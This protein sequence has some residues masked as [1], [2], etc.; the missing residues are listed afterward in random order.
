METKKRKDAYKANALEMP[1]KQLLWLTFNGFFL[2]YNAA[3]LTD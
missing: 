3:I 1:S 2:P